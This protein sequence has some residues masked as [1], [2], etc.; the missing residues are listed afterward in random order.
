MGMMTEELT[1]RR[2]FSRKLLS[3]VVEMAGA[4]EM[5]TGSGQCGP[6]IDKTSLEK[7]VK[8]VDHADAYKSLTE[9][10]TVSLRERLDRERRVRAATTDSPSSE[11]PLDAAIERLRAMRVIDDRPDDE[12]LGF[13]HHGIPT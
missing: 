5:G 6:V 10:I 1:K 2:Y 7:I 9:A 12:V 13:D 11:T 3:K 8:Y 4:I